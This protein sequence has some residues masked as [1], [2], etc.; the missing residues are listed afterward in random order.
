MGSELPGT[1]RSVSGDKLRTFE[2]RCD[3]LEVI[4]DSTN[5][6]DGERKEDRKIEINGR[7]GKAVYE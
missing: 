5:R 2:F 3:H 1:A 4:K 7:D 6:E